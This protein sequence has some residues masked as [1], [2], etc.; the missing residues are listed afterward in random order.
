MMKVLF[1]IL[2]VSLFAFAVLLYPQ[3]VIIT[4]DSV[5]T[6]RITVTQAA[7][8]LPETFAIT[9]TTLP[10]GTEQAA[11]S[12]TLAAE[13]GV[14]PY[15]WSLLSGSL[16]PGLSLNETT[17]E[18]SGSPSAS[19]GYTF[20][21]RATDSQPL[22]DNQQLAITIAAAEGGGGSLSFYEDAED[23]NLTADPSWNAPGGCSV[24]SNGFLEGSDEVAKTTSTDCVWFDNVDEA[25]VWF[26][27]DI[28][29][30]G[31]GAPATDR[32]EIVIGLASDNTELFSCRVEV[33]WD[34][35]CKTPGQ[36][37]MG[38]RGFFFGSLAADSSTYIECHYL[39]GTG[40]DA[41]F[42]CRQDG[43]A[44]ESF[45]AGTAT[46]N[47]DRIIFRDHND[48]AQ[49]FFFDRV[50][51]KDDTWPGGGALSGGGGFTGSLITTDYGAACDGVSD[52][53]PEIQTALDDCASWAGSTL[54]FPA[55]A[56]CVSA[57]KLDHDTC[58][59]VTIEG[60]GATIK[61]GNGLSITDSNPFFHLTGVSNVPIN[62]LTI[63]GNRDN[64]G[65]N[66]S[67]G[68]HSIQFNSVSDTTFREFNSHNGSTDG[69]RIHT[70]NTADTNAYSKNLTFIDSK[71]H[72]NFRNNVTVISG[73][74]IRFLGTC[75]GG[76]AGSC[77]CQ[78]TGANGTNPQ[79]GI[80]WEPNT[81]F[82]EPAIDDGLVDGCLIEDN[83]GGG[84]TTNSKSGSRNI[85]LRNSIIRNNGNSQTTAPTN[86]NVNLGAL[87]DLVEDN[88]IK[89]EVAS[90]CGG[91]F[92][93][94]YM[95]GDPSTGGDGR[96]PLVQN[97][98]IDG[99]PAVG[100]SSGQQHVVYYG[101]FGSGNQFKS[102]TITNAHTNAAGDWCRTGAAGGNSTTEDN[103][104]DAVTQSPNPG[105][106]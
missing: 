53:G 29:R 35:F 18:I 39:K 63:D 96:S 31:S 65:G 17:G 71:W 47:V 13:G 21:V 76:F 26:G 28:H 105:C 64:R 74:N 50:E 10:A 80:D 19:G 81:G 69:I 62:F 57:Q 11:Y 4:G 16:P 49:D 91:R 46:Q 100:T 38:G 20:T 88:W 24:T 43:G 32:D 48:G 103:T 3:S 59:N 1:A 104:V 90:G 67:V 77:T 33:D 56:T 51:A 40:S 22:F 97:N 89:C 54:V 75:S 5:S 72:N 25:Q 8:G 84:H 58:S 79:A 41:V 6:G 7:P 14:T 52:D 55:G 37:A 60:Q 42:E 2:A 95:H 87:G 23:G 78:M 93:I 30:D 101:N 66:E 92:G 106:P 68:G 102:N 99:E 45:T 36:T 61:A 9:T 83:F 94:V 15:T 27:F 82:A 34:L 44:A 12:H 70:S 98:F 86:H 73:W 85:T